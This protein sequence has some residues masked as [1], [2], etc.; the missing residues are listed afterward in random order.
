[1]GGAQR[2]IGAQVMNREK[3][4]RH[5]RVVSIYTE[6]ERMAAGRQDERVTCRLLRSHGPALVPRFGPESPIP[7]MHC[8]PSGQFTS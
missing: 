1:M 4:P 8:H 3:A 5:P 2:W 6:S 7:R